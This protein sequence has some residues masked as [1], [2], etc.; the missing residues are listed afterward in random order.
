MH[1]GALLCRVSIHF[2]TFSITWNT[3]LCDSLV[4]ELFMLVASYHGEVNEF[5]ETEIS[6]KCTA[7]HRIHVELNTP[8]CLFITILS[9]LLDVHVKHSNR[10]VNST[11]IVVLANGRI[12]RM[13]L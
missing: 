8:T 9:P 1:L 12:N 2:I 11:E 13:F 4:V 3:L 10:H 6:I 5:Q 7:V